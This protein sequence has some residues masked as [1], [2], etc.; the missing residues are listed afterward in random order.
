[1][2]QDDQ[3]E[4]LWQNTAAPQFNITALF[5]DQSDV[6]WLSVNAQGIT[7]IDLRAMPFHSHPYRRGFVTD[8]LEEAGVSPFLVPAAWAAPSVAYFFRQPPDHKNRLYVSADPYGIDGNFHVRREGFSEIQQPSEKQD[9][10]GNG[11]E[12]RWRDFYF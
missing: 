1:M 6:L 8:I 3:P 11:C 9:L 5:V 2:N 12:D 7:K 4:P 10:H